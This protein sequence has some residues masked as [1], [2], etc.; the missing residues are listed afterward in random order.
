NVAARLEQAAAPG[1]IL[2]GEATYRLVRDAVQV[3]ELEPLALKGKT[4]GIQAFRLLEVSPGAAGHRRR[5]DSPMVGREHEQ[6]ALRQAFDR[7]VQD[8]TCHLFTILGPAGVGKSRLVSELVGEIDGRARV[9]SGRCLS[10]G[11]GIT[12]WPLA[13]LVA[14]LGDD[15]VEVVRAALPHAKDADRVAEL[16]AS[17]VGAGAPSGSSEEISWAARRLLEELARERPLVVVFDD[18]HWAEPTFLDLVDHLSDWA[19]ESPILL[20]CMARP[21]LLDLRPGWSGGKLNATSVLLEPLGEDDS[22]LLVEN[23]LGQAELP[24][25]VGRRIAAAA[26]GNPLFVEEM[27]AMLIDEGTLE[28]RNGGW[29]VAGDLSE[30]TVPPS[31]QALLAARLDRLPADERAV[32]EGASVEG[33]IFHRAAVAELSPEDLRLRLSPL[34]QALLRKEFIRPDQ[35]LF[36]GHEAFR[37]RHLLLR[38]AAYDALPKQA[39]AELHGRF[40]AWLEE[41]AGE[42]AG[43]VEEI[44]GY[45]LEQAYR[46]FGQLGQL[47]EAAE[48]VGARAAERLGSAGRRALAR[49]DM[50]AAAN[51]ISRA[52]EL[53]PAA[54]RARLALLPE[55]GEA[56]TALGELERAGRTLDDAIESA[57]RTGDRRI[58]MRGRVVRTELDITLG[59]SMVEGLATAEAATRTFEEL[60]DDVGLAKAWGQILKLRFFLGRAAE[61]QEAAPRALEHARRA[62]ARRE[63]SEAQAWFLS[64]CLHGPMPVTEGLRHVE[65]VLADRHAPGFTRSFALYAKAGFIAMLGRFDE[66]RAVQR[67]SMTIADEL[68]LKVVAG[69]AGGGF[70]EIELLAG[71]PAA[72]EQVARPAFETLQAMGDRGFLS[73]LAAC[74]AEAAYQQRRYDEAEKLCGIVEETGAGDDML[75]QV[76]QRR[77][78][79]KLL[80]RSGRLDEG[81]ALVRDALSI[82]ERCDYVNVHAR[83]LEDLAEVLGLAGRAGETTAALEQALDLY[84]RK[85]NAVSAER[86]R[87]RLAG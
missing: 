84:E 50:T 26:E 31:I 49:D 76:D 53:L 10:Y 7:T 72:A 5:L 37:F 45:H 16:I 64:T 4:G 22:A 82:I 51:L 38:D 13:E 67:A 62:G 17:A 6:M 57:Q 65:E 44:L 86:L 70:A 3:E 81:E 60:G 58:E 14:E 75:A 87:R 77:L 28:R 32:I 15:P 71:D 24:D 43:E 2:I 80:A 23:L 79:G 21:E 74:L 27:V 83:V 29:I 63:E 69:S 68:G 18:C 19:R 48:Q 52:L 39:R 1:E 66:A 40:A 61:A 20:L 35:G 42:R 8:R 85:E 9:L 46:Y 11:D 36:A 25:A 34:L 73:F 30:S 59:G 41:A 55:L 78:R 47:D 54:S 56:L 12:F 33:K